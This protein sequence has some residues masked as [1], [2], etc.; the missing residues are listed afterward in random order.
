M[1]KHKTLL[2]LINVEITSNKKIKPDYVYSLVFKFLWIKLRFAIVLY[3]AYM[4]IYLPSSGTFFA[5]N[6]KQF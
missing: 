3:L 6:F 5:N 1:L 2:E 4:F